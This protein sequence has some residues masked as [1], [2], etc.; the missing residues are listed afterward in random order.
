[1][2]NEKAV[3]QPVDTEVLLKPDLASTEVKPD[4][5]RSPLLDLAGERARNV[6]GVRHQVIQ[7]V[8]RSSFDD[9]ETS[10]ISRHA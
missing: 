2:A 3:S 8:V 1:M 4:P 5:A 7:V 6:P 10:H 9:T